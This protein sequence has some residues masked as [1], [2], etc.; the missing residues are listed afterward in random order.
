ML[1]PEFK[2]SEEKLNE[3]IIGEISS[4]T[5]LSQHSF[6]LDKIIR[7]TYENYAIQVLDMCVLANNQIVAST[8]NNSL[9]LFDENFDLI[10]RI[11][12][13]DDKPIYSFG[14][15]YNPTNN[16]I[17]ASNW[18]NDCVYMLD[19]GLNKLKSYGS[20]GMNN[21]NN[22]Y[23][24]FGICI[25]ND[26]LYICDASN[27]RIQILNPDLAY[28]GTIN[29][30]YVPYT[31]KIS[32]TSICV[33]GSNCT[34]NFYDLNT[35]ALKRQYTNV[36]G[37]INEIDSV[38]YF[39]TFSPTKK[40]CCYDTDGNSIEEIDIEQLSQYVSYV[41]DGLIINFNNSLI[42][43]NNKGNVLKF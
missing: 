17:Y 13:I 27:Q 32:K 25:N 41:W 24:P 28:I 2:P 31:I 11:E 29:L 34:L 7:N 8:N 5:F 3:S 10:K 42:M 39:V 14:V 6:I 23:R 40:L 19:L 12:R 33:C 21:N 9:S 1:K 22:L 15:A 30:N 38:F 36:S 18:S 35:R 20:Q 26:L 16:K 37:R 43:A 4:K